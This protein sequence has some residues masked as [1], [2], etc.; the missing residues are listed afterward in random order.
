MAVVSREESAGTWF[1]GIVD[2]NGMSR[3]NGSSKISVT[4]SARLTWEFAGLNIAPA[5]QTVSI[6]SGYVTTLVLD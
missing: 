2:Q 4:H 1:I 3:T 5:Q 6:E